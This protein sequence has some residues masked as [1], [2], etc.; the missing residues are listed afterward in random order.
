MKYLF[1]LILPLFVAC[2]GTQKYATFQEGSDSFSTLD[3]VFERSLCNGIPGTVQVKIDFDQSDNLKMLELAKEDIT[4]GTIVSDDIEPICVSSYPFE[5][6]IFNNN[7]HTSTSCFTLLE[8]EQSKF[9]TFVMLSPEVQSLPKSS[10]R[11][12]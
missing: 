9:V 12:Y 6:S 8:N 7:S 10:C 11:Y 5:V 4:K 3:H 1:I 2:T